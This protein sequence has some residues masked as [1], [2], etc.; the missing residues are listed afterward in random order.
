MQRP[1]QKNERDAEQTQYRRNLLRRQFSQ[2]HHGHFVTTSGRSYE[3]GKKS[4]AQ[5][6]TR[7]I[8]QPLFL[9]SADPVRRWG[10]DINFHT[11][12]NYRVPDLWRDIGRDERTVIIKASSGLDIDELDREGLLGTE[13][14]Q[15]MMQ[16]GME[17]FTPPGV[18]ANTMA[19]ME[20][21][22]LFS[23]EFLHDFSRI[24][25]TLLQRLNLYPWLSRTI[26]AQSDGAALQRA[27]TYTYKTPHFS[28]YTAQAYHPGEYGNQEHIFGISLNSE[29][30]IFHTHPAVYP[31][32]KPPFDNSPTYWVG[33]GRMPH[34]VQ[35][36]NISLAIYLLPA[37]KSRFEKELIPYTH[38]YLPVNSFDQIF[39]DGTCLVVRSGKT[40]VAFHTRY[41]L[42]YNER[43]SEMVQNGRETYWICEAGCA[44]EET[45]EAFIQRMRLT[46]IKYHDG[47]L[48]YTSGQKTLT[49]E[50]G[51]GFYVDGH[52]VDT[53]YPRFD[54]PY[55]KAERKAKEM[56]FR[57][58]NKTLYLHFDHMIRREN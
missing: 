4:G 1:P 54:S 31:G 58:N 9:N 29:I 30:S 22:T 51:A 41:E 24:R 8:T 39:L 32:Q 37:H 25:Y 34:A 57:H 48:E 3:R 16:W 52:L 28:M 40:F 47:T 38:L 23:N 12:Q 19:A 14:Q 56:T 18:I 17:A 13:G 27:N 55:I 43:H 10:M 15:I 53:H 6:S 44:D 49:L 35:D 2:S 50:Y 11:I 46:R 7:R 5:A 20:N 42:T 21:Y 45:F 36:E 26:H 33:N